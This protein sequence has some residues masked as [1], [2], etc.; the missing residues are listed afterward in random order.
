MGFSV[1]AWGIDS[2]SAMERALDIGVDGMTINYPDVL[3]N[4]LKR[5][6]I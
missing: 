3:F 2:I 1:R 6:N 5:R 4:A